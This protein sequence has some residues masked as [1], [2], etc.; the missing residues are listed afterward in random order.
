MNEYQDKLIEIIA[1]KVITAES[2]DRVPLPASLGEIRWTGWKQ[3]KDSIDPHAQLVWLFP[4]PMKCFYVDLPSMCH[5]PFER[6]A[7][8]SVGGLASNRKYFHEDVTAEE[9]RDWFKEAFALLLADVIASSPSFMAE[10]PRQG[11]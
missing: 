4:Y 1:A 8:F 7:A 3:T 11:S 6:G 9:V 2:I 5:G 10:S